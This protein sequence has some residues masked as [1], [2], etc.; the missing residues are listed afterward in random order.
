M[1]EDKA[2]DELNE[3]IKPLLFKYGF[4]DPLSWKRKA[5]RLKYAADRL[6]D[7][8]EASRT[9][10]L[11]RFTGAAEAGTGPVAAWHAAP[12]SELGKEIADISLLTEYCLLMGYAVENLLKG[13]LMA[14]HPEYFKPDAK[15]TVIRSHNLIRL[16]QRCSLTLTPDEQDLLGRLTEHIEWVAKYPVPLDISGMYPRKRPDGTWDGPLDR[17]ARDKTKYIAESFYGKLRDEIAERQNTE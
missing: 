16:C 9:R 12:E 3:S 7:L 13:L 11:E 8:Y 15:M 14:T 1:I 4:L 2:W 17:F 6:F 10:Y 5:A